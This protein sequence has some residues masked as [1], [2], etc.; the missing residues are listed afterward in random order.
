MRCLQ[1]ELNR[2]H[3]RTTKEPSME[4]L[5]TIA[6]R[7]HARRNLH[8]SIC[9]FQ[10]AI[11]LLPS[12]TA[13]R[14]V[15][16]PTTPALGSR[17]PQGPHLASA[18]GGRGQG[19]GR[20]LG[21]EELQGPRRAGQGRW[22]SSPA[23]ATR[24]TA[25]NFLTAW[26]RP[27]PRPIPSAAQL[28]DLCSRPRGPRGPAQLCLDDRRQ[29]RADRRRQHAALLRPLAG[30][31][32]IGSRRPWSRSAASSRPTSPLPPSCSSTRASPTIAC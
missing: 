1:C 7:D 19:P 31:R 32:A 15:A 26:P 6:T 27:L 10:F 13:F 17:H 29:D 2:P 25:R 14:A 4:A 28:V 16:A 8:F 22:R 30:R 18:A 21:A 11:L 3:R 5:R 12:P 24:P 20:R 23:S 9:I